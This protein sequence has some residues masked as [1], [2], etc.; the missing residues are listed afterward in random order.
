MTVTVAGEEFILHADR[1]AYWVS[2]KTLLVA[3][4]HLGKIDHFRGAGVFVPQHAAMDNYER[5][6]SLLLQFEPQRIII[7]GDL[8]HSKLN[9]DWK[10][11]SD[12][13][14]TFPEV[15]VDLVLGNHD[16]LDPKLYRKNDMQL[17]PD[18]LDLPPFSFSHYREETPGAYNI[19]GHVH[20]GVRLRGAPGHSLR[21]PCFYFGVHYGKLPAFGMFTGTSLVQPRTGDQVVVIS[22]DELV[23]MTSNNAF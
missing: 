10:H 5:L 8:F 13:R 22:D 21:L 11:F 7:L 4:L 14:S 20:P 3:D 19:S 12:F 23:S 2:H 9:K 15:E 6:S 1:A 18:V 17:Y 16:I